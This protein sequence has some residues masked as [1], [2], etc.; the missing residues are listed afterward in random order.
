MKIHAIFAAAP[1]GATLSS[2]RHAIMCQDGFV[3]SVQASR[4]HYCTP[5]ENLPIGK[6][7]EEF[8]LGYP[9]EQEPLLDEYSCDS[10]VF[11]CVPAEVVDAVIEKHGGFKKYTQLKG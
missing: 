6:Q 11:A 4:F 8:E 9:S 1:R 3:V 2:V 7:Y 10:T 5:R